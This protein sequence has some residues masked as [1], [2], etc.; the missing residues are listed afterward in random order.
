[1]AF[2]GPSPFDGDPV[3]NYLD[4]VSNQPPATVQA[5]L[6]SAFQD[7]I[8]GGAVRHMPAEFASMLGLDLLPMPSRHS[9]YSVTPNARSY[10]HCSTSQGNSANESAPYATTWRVGNS[11]PRSRRQLAGFEVIAEANALASQTSTRTSSTLEPLSEGPT[12]PGG[13]T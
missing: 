8:Q 12:S 1:M 7:V 10:L 11:S 13:S 6:A 2:D 9:T 3:F 4:R 5:E